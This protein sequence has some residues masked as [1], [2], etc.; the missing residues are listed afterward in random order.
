MNVFRDAAIEKAA[1]LKGTNGGASLKAIIKIC[2][3]LDGERGR[4]DFGNT[5][6]AAMALLEALVPNYQLAD[7]IL[8]IREHVE[9]PEDIK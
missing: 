9:I 3:K 7:V 6:S 2:E 4:L 5:V 1:Q 8:S